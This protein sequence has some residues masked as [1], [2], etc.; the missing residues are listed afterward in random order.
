MEVSDLLN[1]VDILEYVSQYTDFEERNGEYWALS[2]L[3]AENTPSFSIN[4]E[5]Q[6]YYDFSSGTGGN[7]L[8]FIQRYE[9]CDLYRSVEILKGYANIDETI[10]ITKRLETTKIIK[11]FRKQKESS[12][13]SAGIV[14]DKTY[15][16]KYVID[17]NKMDIWIKEGIPYEILIRHGV[18]VDK[19]SNRIIYPIYDMSGNLINISG[20]TL[21]ENF[22]EKKIRKYTYYKPLRELN[23]IYWLYQNLKNIKEK[24]EV[25]IFEGAKSVMIAE[26]WGIKNTGALLTSHL[27]KCQLKILIQLGVRVVF[28]LDEDV[29][30]EKDVQI[31]KLKRYAKIEIVKNTNKILSEKMSPVDQG[32]N[33]WKN[34]YEQRSAFR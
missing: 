24:N 1:T 22:K 10:N 20:R 11:K 23:T 6:W 8:S 7:L 27:N 28:A 19:I 5:K 15:M 32:E 13:E 2:P 16:D 21:D 34:L 29:D 17:K 33:V 31:Q 30:V 18:R 25:I 12:K 3:K 4:R 14:L 9:R 26:A